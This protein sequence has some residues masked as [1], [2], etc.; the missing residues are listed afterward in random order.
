MAGQTPLHTV[1]QLIEAINQGNIDQAIAL[2]E[3]EAAFVVEPGKVAVGREAIRTA[4]DTLISLGPTISTLNYKIIEADGTA[5]YCS[6]WS[7]SGAAP[8]GTPVKQEGKSTDV[9]RRNDDGNWL[10]A[11]DNPIGVAILG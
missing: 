9:L 2:Y 3:P 10:I 4:F 5:L 1:E 11:V 6:D 8:D 7:M